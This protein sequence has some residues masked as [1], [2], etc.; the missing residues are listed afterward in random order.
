MIRFH[1][2]IAPPA[3]MTAGLTIQAETERRPGPSLDIA[4]VV[5]YPADFGGAI[6]GLGF[7]DGRFYSIDEEA[8]RTT[9]AMNA[10]S[11]SNVRESARRLARAGWLHRYDNRLAAPRP[12]NP[13]QFSAQISSFVIEYASAE[14]AS[15]AFA[16][17]TRDVPSGDSPLI[18]DESAVTTLSGVTRD[19]NTEY[20]AA[21]LVFRVGPLLCSIVYADLLG[22]APDLQL[23]TSV[24]Q[25]VAERGRVV[26]DRQTIALGSMTLQLDRT[27]ATEGVSR[28]DIYD[29]RA[30]TLTPAF[31]E[32]DASLQD[33]IARFAATI[34]VFS[35]RAEGSFTRPRQNREA[36]GSES[37]DPTPTSV[38]T[39]DGP[40][41]PPATNATPAAGAEIEPASDE[42]APAARL[43][44]HTTLLAF[45]GVADAEAWLLTQ[46]QT[47][48]EQATRYREVLDAPVIG[49]ASTTFEL[50]DEGDREPERA[51]GFEIYARAGG[52]V[53]VL[54]VES[55]SGI[56]LNGAAG[57]MSAQIDCIDQG[58]CLEPASLP[59][60]LFGGIDPPVRPKPRPTPT[61][62]PVLLPPPE[63]TPI[64]TQAQ[65]LAPTPIPEVAPPPAEEP[66]AVPPVEPSP[67]PEQEEVPPPTETL[68][69]EPAGTPPEETEIP[70]EE[71]TPAPA[72]EQTPPAGASSPAPAPTEAVAPTPA[73]DLG[74]TPVTEQ[75]TPAPAEPTT[76]TGEPTTPAPGEEPPPAATEAPAEPPAEAPAVDPTPA[77]M[78]APDTSVDAGG[79]SGDSGSSRDDRRKN[80][81][82]RRK[83]RDR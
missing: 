50:R 69:P 51:P 11:E 31:E 30:G 40:P 38:I 21:K 64:P 29:V 63:P 41:S 4:R 17:L 49:D 71:P 57:L 12:D 32:D 1:R 18:G 22:Q 59:K 67:V 47:A 35:S 81:R 43:A 73:P 44:L 25:L 48:R 76:T 36:R 14:D 45:P 56:S 52:I 26:N 72:E 46:V 27:H 62:E 68:P 16:A 15:A 5:P 20:Q 80:D 77:P 75:P 78:P 24:A 54:T 70:L 83:D 39:I 23:L 9:A 37:P 6:P 13:E 65:E 8:T 55:T 53:A 34:D 82:D 2:A 10:S 3:A 58:G 42:A 33:R 66:I 7:L 28:R 74:P 61:P 60:S 19:T 79:D